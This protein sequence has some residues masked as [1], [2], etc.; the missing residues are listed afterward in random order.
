MKLSVR[1]SA[2]VVQLPAALFWHWRHQHWRTHTGSAEN[3][4][5][6]APQLQRP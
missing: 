2:L 5:V 1:N 4:A 6:T 3:V